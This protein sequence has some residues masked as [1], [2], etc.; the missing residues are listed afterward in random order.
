VTGRTRTG[1]TA[2]SGTAGTG[3]IAP[4]AIASTAR[5]GTLDGFRPS[6]FPWA[7]SHAPQIAHSLR[8][9]TA[10]TV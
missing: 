3:R 9:P 10:T 7:G 4:A 5:A 2:K 6:L 1:A 8:L